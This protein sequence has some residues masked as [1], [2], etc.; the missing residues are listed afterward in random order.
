MTR[1]LLGL[2][3][4]ALIVAQDG[5]S[6]A[7]RQL[8]RDIFRELIEINTTDSLGNTP[9]AARAMAARLRA[10]GFPAADVQVLIGPDPKHGNLVAR[11]RGS[12]AG[13]RP[14][15]TFAHLDVV[16]ARRS[17]WSVDPFVLLERDGYF[18]G[19]GTTDD[20][21]GDAILVADFI[22]LKRAGF[23]PARD[24]IL[25]LTGDEETA[26]SCIQWLVTKHRP[27]IDAEFAL[28]TDAGGGVLRDGRRV[29]FA[30]Q[31]SE[32]VYATYVLEAVDKGGHS[33]LPRP[34][35][36]PIYR[37]APVLERLAQ[38]QFPVKLNEVSRSFFERSAAIE[39]GQLAEDMRGVLR[40]PPDS[41][42]VA[43]LSAVPFYNSKLRTT[44]V[45]T[46]V[47]GGH[48]E[49]ALP[50]TARVTINCRILPGEPAAEVEATLRRLVA[51]D[52][53]TIR[54]T[55]APVP[56]PPSPLTPAI[57]GPIER[58]VAQQ[59]PNVPIVPI[60]E[61]GATDGLFL[62]NAGIPTYGVS[63]VFEEQNDVRAH[64]R[65][66]RIRVQSFYEALEFWYQMMRALAGAV[67]AAR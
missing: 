29:M 61:A 25:V 35:D 41:A 45:A 12:G 48:A 65:D 26:G 43:R 15:I 20:K 44:C 51:D 19:R 3:A 49:N 64:G 56:S 14:I 7:D 28:N 9:R 58:L 17:D 46:M 59:F 52:R 60:M 66:E 40:D 39:T 37:L 34:A 24:L 16:P 4:A 32:K 10:A 18:Y 38:Y 55:Y 1:G 27:L 47:D 53:I 62:R 54:T 13:G 5:P 42:A 57:M 8:A 21:V 31:A 36:N 23:R 6:A 67:D 2:T 33:S 50:Q 30:V 63:A 11:L 22:R